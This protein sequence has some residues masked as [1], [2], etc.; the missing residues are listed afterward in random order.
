VPAYWSVKGYY[1]RGAGR[2]ITTGRL[3]TIDKYDKTLAT[4]RL[5]KRMNMRKRKRKQR[6]T[7]KTP[8]EG[9]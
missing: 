9:S 1:T 5:L 3:S 7:A 4:V 6:K 8:K 2:L